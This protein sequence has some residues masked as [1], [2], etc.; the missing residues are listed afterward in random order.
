MRITQRCSLEYGKPVALSSDKHGGFR[1]NKARV[2]RGE[3]ITQFGGALHD[4]NI[5]RILPTRRRR[6]G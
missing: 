1:L 4:L 3:G 2:A 6:P 5:E